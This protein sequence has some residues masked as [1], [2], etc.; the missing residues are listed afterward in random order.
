MNRLSIV[1]Q[2][3]IVLLRE[4]GNILLDIWHGYLPGEILEILKSYIMENYYSD[5]RYDYNYE[6]KQ[7]IILDKFGNKL[8]NARQN[9]Y[10]II[11]EFYNNSIVNNNIQLT[12]KRNL[13]NASLNK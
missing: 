10:Q 11:Y 3:S 13:I 8:T 7:N 2:S 1:E 12:E 5:F 9:Y 4:Y 6:T